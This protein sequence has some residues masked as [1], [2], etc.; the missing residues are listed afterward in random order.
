MSMSK[1]QSPQDELLDSD[2][3]VRIPNP[4]PLDEEIDITPMIDIVFLLLIF[5][6]VASKMNQDS[7]VALP[8][9]NYGAAVTLKDCVVV[10]IKRGTGEN[11][12]VARQDGSPFSTDL[13]QQT[14]EIVQYVQQGLDSG[15]MQVM[16][17]SEGAARYGEVDRVKKAVSEAIEEGSA[18]NVAVLQQNPT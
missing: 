13:E 14:V 12:I 2:E 5:F 10:L 16:I 17:K 4:P 6:L 15:K 3:P 7:A 11:A 18:I 1:P 8:A 9:A